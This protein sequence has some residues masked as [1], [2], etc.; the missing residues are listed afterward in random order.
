MDWSLEPTFE[1]LFHSLSCEDKDLLSPF[2][3]NRLSYSTQTAVCPPPLGGCARLGLG[4]S[5]RP[6]G[7]A[8]S[9]PLGGSARPLW[10]GLGGSARPLWAGVPAPS[11]RTGPPL[12]AIVPA[13]EADT[14]APEGCEYSNFEAQ[15][16]SYPGRGG[17]GRP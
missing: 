2:E 14:P 13:L 1:A 15:K 8:C 5:A 4:R 17:G 11:W 3:L 10:A 16:A 7:W 12:R 9:P 6:T